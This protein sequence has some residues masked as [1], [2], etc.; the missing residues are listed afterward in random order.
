M[1]GKKRSLKRAIILI[2]TWVLLLVLFLSFL[3]ILQS[4]FAHDPQG[5]TILSQSWAGYIISRSDEPKVQVT[6]I[7][8]SWVVPVVNASLAPDF[9]SV[10]IGVGGQLDHTL[11]QVGTEQDAFNGSTT[12]YAWYE[13]L[14]SFAVR[15]GTLA[16]SPGDV[17]VA[18]LRL[19]DSAANRWSIQISDSTTRQY[20]GTAVT[21]NSTGSS[22]EWI[23]E[24][25]TVDNR[26]TALA[27]F[28]RVSFSGCHLSSHNVSGS[29]KLFYYSRVEMT[30]NAL[31]TQLT[32]VSTLTADGTGFSVSYIS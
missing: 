3:S 19:I 29:I 13:L 10:W 20:F 23:I 27:D 32:S 6:A 22:G 9:A 17:V 12:Y 1:A 2:V 5:E 21:Y 11:I 31:T 30:N 16:V 7:N 24:R 25:P 14:P 4:F 26:L 8:A 15:I 18:S 28:G